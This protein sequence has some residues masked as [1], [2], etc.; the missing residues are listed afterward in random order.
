VWLQERTHNLNYK[1]CPFPA[2]TRD[3]ESEWGRLAPKQENLENR[4]KGREKAKKE[5]RPPPDW[6]VQ[7][8]RHCVAKAEAEGR[9]PPAWALTAP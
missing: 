1:S 6:L 2:M 3:A 8:A 7:A 5:G 9:D 4:I